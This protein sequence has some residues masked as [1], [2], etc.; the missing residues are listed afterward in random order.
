MAMKISIY[1]GGAAGK[2]IKTAS[3][4]VQ[5]ADSM[6]VD[7]VWSAE[8]WAQ[9][10]ITTLAYLAAK[11][12]RIHLGTG[13]MQISARAPA[14][15]AMTALSLN[16]ISG[17]RFRL[18]LGVSGPPRQHGLAACIMGQLGIAAGQDVCHARAGD[19]TEARVR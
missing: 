12:E 18:G 15:T 19:D 13:I 7:C 2:D 11:T 14:M 6:G 5:A 4:V 8:A 17:G 10:A 3:E 1:V 16:E 9:D